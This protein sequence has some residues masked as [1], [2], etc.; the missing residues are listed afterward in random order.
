MEHS[1]K[2]AAVDLWKQMLDRA[3]KN[4]WSAFDDPDYLPSDTERAARVEAF[5][6]A[7]WRADEI[8]AMQ[9]R[10]HERALDAPVTSPGV[11]RHSEVMLARVVDALLSGLSPAQHAVAQSAH[12]VVEPKSGPLISKINVVMTDQ[13]IIA[14]GTHFTRFCGLVA[15]AYVRTC[16]LLP[17]ETGIGFNEN[18][19][20]QQLRR[21]PDLVRYWWR[22]FTSTWDYTSRRST[23]AVP[24]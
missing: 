23:F 2:V 8:A 11:S 3:R 9:G 18:G 20:R 12:F 16:N 13:S 21:R 5:Q 6:A 17:F 24:L 19:L 14:M 15:R 4:D 22:I 7:G 10:T 1:N